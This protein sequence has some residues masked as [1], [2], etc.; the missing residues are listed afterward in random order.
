MLC[1]DGVYG[2]VF[3]YMKNMHARTRSNKISS[4]KRRKWLICQPC[5]WTV[6]TELETLVLGQAVVALAVVVPVVF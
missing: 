3:L 1:E 4:D 2:V 6:E 5:T